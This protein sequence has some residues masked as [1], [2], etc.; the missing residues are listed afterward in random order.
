MRTRADF[1][2][3]ETSVLSGRLWR[4]GRPN[5]LNFKGATLV[6]RSGFCVTEGD[7]YEVECA[8][9]ANDG[10]AR[11]LAVVQYL[12]RE[13]AQLAEPISPKLL[14]E[15]RPPMTGMEARSVL[16]LHLDGAEAPSNRGFEEPASREAGAAARRSI[17]RIFRAMGWTGAI[18][19]PGFTQDSK[20]VVVP[21]PYLPTGV[22]RVRWSGPL[23]GALPKPLV[24][25]ALAA[26]QDFPTAGEVGTLPFKMPPAQRVTTSWRPPQVPGTPAG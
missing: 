1:H 24:D 23:A 14:Y 3:Y 20:M 15:L 12:E 16:A 6:A 11:A 25:F 10:E 9:G 8:L 13:K 19:L 2:G 7:P 21:R 5:A 22:L 18:V 4:A 26:R 17:L